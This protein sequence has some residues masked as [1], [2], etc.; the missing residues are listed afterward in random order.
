LEFIDE[1]GVALEC[2]NARTMRF[3]VMNG[4]RCRGANLPFELS[5][6]RAAAS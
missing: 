2:G 4:A 6:W 1:N 5:M 3:T